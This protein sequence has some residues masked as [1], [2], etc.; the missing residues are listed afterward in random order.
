MLLTRIAVAERR[1]PVSSSACLTPDRGGSL[2][3]HGY[4]GVQVEL[5]VAGER[6]RALPD[7]AGG[8]FDGAGD[9]DRLLRASGPDRA[10]LSAVDPHDETRLG[11]GEMSALI[12]EIDLILD[13]AKPGPERRGL[14]RLRAMAVRCR[15]EGGQLLFTGD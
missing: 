2:I 11:P 10:L 3:D 8:L 7:P 6:I 14:M 1:Q 12:A 5:V 9:F 4:M 15:Q 13:K